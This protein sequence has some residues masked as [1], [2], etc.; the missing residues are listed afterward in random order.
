MMHKRWEDAFCTLKVARKRCEDA[1]C[2][3]C[4]FKVIPVKRWEGAS[5]SKVRAN[6][7]VNHVDSALMNV[8][9]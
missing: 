6:P 8:E 4:P 7:K 3:S 2:F 9:S 5:S 1:L